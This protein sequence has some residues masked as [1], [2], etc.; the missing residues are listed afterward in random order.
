MS[1]D[2]ATSDSAAEGS[3]GAAANPTAAWQAQFFDDRVREDP[4]GAFG[5]GALLR[6]LWRKRIELTLRY[7][8]VGEIHRARLW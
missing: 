5:R 7:A 1:R 3:H 2:P 8:Q 4:A 6:E